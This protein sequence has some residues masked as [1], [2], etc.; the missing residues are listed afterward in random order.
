MI[1]T[2]ENNIFLPF[3]SLFPFFLFPYL[4]PHFGGGGIFL[5]SCS[6]YNLTKIFIHDFTMPNMFNYIQRQQISSQQTPS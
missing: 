5:H 2:L 3:P 6:T 4:P 1:S